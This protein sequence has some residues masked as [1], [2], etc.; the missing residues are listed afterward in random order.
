MRK[1]KIEKKTIAFFVILG[2]FIISGLSLGPRITGYTVLKQQ[3]QE[4]EMLK[5]QHEVLVDSYQNNLSILIDEIDSINRDIQVCKESRDQVYEKLNEYIERTVDYKTEINNIE[6]K[7]E[8]EKESMGNELDKC[9]Y[10][11]GKKDRDYREILN[12][13]GNK[14]CC[15]MKVFNPKISSFDV[16]DYEIKCKEG[17]VGKYRIFC[18]V[19][20]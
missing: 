5:Q 11:L 18:E 13:A 15:M 4:L 10:D 17:R 20:S 16:E 3:N 2:V 14:I 19:V 7:C 12:F 6:S 8:R 9:R 1:N